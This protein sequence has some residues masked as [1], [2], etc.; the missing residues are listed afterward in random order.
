AGEVPAE[1]MLRVFNM[2]IGFVLVVAEADAGRALSLLAGA[3]DVA[4]RIGRIVAGERG[5][6]VRHRRGARG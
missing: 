3:G 5:V 4:T 6:D 2:G 1:E